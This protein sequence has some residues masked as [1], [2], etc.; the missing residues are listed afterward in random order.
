M[1]TKVL[2]FTLLGALALPQ[3]FSQTDSAR[4][5][6]TVTDASGA[7][8]PAASIAVKNEKTGQERKVSA[9]GHGVYLAQQL[10][11]STYSLTA[12]APGMANAEFK[13]VSLQVGQERTLNVTLSPS[14]MTC[15]LYTS[16]A[17]DE[18]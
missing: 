13:G 7:V 12:T 2:R 3:L 1:L 17:A 8:I 4:M 14:S 18:E 6:G 11:P 5:T 16:D 10:Q 9:D 15:L